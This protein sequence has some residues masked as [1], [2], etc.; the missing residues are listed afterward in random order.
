MALPRISVDVEAR[1]SDAEEGLDRVS[2][3]IR[4]LGRESSITGGRVGAL[5]TR[6][7]GTGRDSR[8]LG[9]GIQNAAFQLGDFATQVGAGTSAS[10]ALGQQLPQ[11]FV[12]FGALGAVIGAAVAVAVPL[13]RSMGGLTSD[14]EVLKDVLGTTAPLFTTLASALRELGP[15]ATQVAEVIVNNFDRIVITAGVVAS[16][17]GVKLVAGFVAARV[18]T[19]TLAGSM[20]FL[21]GALLRTGI[22]ALIIGAGELVYQFSRLVEGASGVGNAFVMVGA[23]FSEVWGRIRQATSLLG[24]AMTG[25]ALVI[26]GAFKTMLGTIGELITN[27]FNSWIEGLNLVKGGLRGLPG[28]GEFVGEDTGLF[29]EGTTGL[30]SEGQ[31]LMQSGSAVMTSAIGELGNLG[32]ALESVTAIREVLASIKDEKIDLPSLLGGGTEDEDG[33]GGRGGK[34][35]PFVEQNELR[36]KSLE[37]LR[38]AGQSTWSAL[39]QFVQ[40]FAGKNKAAAVAAIAIQKGLSIAQIV[41][42]TA[43]AKMRALAELGPLAGPPVAAKIGL[44]GKLQAGLVA[45]TGLAQ[46]ASAAGGGGGGGSVNSLVASAQ[47]GGRAAAA[48]QGPQRP[49]VSL[50]LVGDQ[51]FSR[52]QIVQ[53]AEALN[54]SSR[55]GQQLVSITGAR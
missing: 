31:G 9:R 47:R 13:S 6:F 2:S 12:G 21:R 16:F 34:K 36:I 29:G 26:E 19:M 10:I 51:G 49:N 41:A 43:A 27:F 46:A 3:K 52:A 53:I 5:S 40:Q 28:V 4:G 35:D 30:K 42:N 37:M 32:G 22:G 44:Y 15:I 1:T 14:M 39:G 24:E 33:E 7:R 55:D 50:T 38:S 25:L 54:D 20:A 23:V 11:L 8:V 17:F 18:A 45:A 48:S